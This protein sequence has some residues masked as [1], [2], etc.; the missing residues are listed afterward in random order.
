M[1]L[2]WPLNSVTLNFKSI[3]LKNG[4]HVLLEGRDVL[5]CEMREICQ[6]YSSMDPRCGNKICTYVEGEYQFPLKS[7]VTVFYNE[8][9][10]ETDEEEFEDYPLKEND[11]GNN[12]YDNGTKNCLLSLHVYNTQ[13]CKAPRKLIILLMCLFSYNLRDPLKIIHW[14][15]FEF[16]LEKLHL[17]MN[18][19]VGLKLNSQ[20]TKFIGTNLIGLFEFIKTPFLLLE[21]CISKLLM[22]FEILI[23]MVV[24]FGNAKI[25]MTMVAI[26]CDLYFLAAIPIFLVD[27]LVIAPLF[28]MTN[29]VLYFLFLL[30]RGLKW[31]PLKERVEPMMIIIKDL[32]HNSGWDMDRLLLS[33]IIFTCTVFLYPTIASYSLLFFFATKGKEIFNRLFIWIFSLLQEEK[34]QTQTQKTSQT[35]IRVGNHFYPKISSAFTILSL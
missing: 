7:I 27:Y 6:H 26:C 29:M 33:S 13:N 2:L 1:A 12:S 9:D 8:N 35:T 34:Y 4:K 32:N 21:N 24:I 28:Q 18:W 20:L 23:P 15:Q 22:I 14:I 17:L 25:A 30:F 31:N 11:N 16:F 3:Y 10:E 19:P 5:S